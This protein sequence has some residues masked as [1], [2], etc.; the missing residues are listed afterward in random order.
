MNVPV[1]RSPAGVVLPA[2]VVALLRDSFSFVGPGS[3]LPTTGPTG[4]SQVSTEVPVYEEPNRVIVPA[5]PVAIL[6][7]DGTFVGPGNPLPTTGGGGGPTTAEDVSLAGHSPLDNVQEALDQLLYV[8]IDASPTGGGSANE[9]GAS[10]ASVNFTWSV[11]KDPTTQSLN[12][13]VGSIDPTLRDYLFTGPYTTNQTF[14]V[15]VS[16]GTTSDQASVS[17]TFQP[18]RYWGTSALTSLNNAQ[19]LALSQELS[20]SRA[21]SLTYDC[22]GG[23]YPYFIY[24]TSLGALTS[25]TVGGLAFSDFTQSIQSVTNAQGYVQN[26]YV[27]RFNGIQTGAAINVSWA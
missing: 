12:Q 8:A 18:K 14:T 3:P 26:Y 25:V 1:Y 22:T 15:T 27:T 23:A 7:S 9:I 2:D 20:S 4:A 16:D 10:V 11:N 19:I 17:V 21:K 5:Q 13:G 24:P 6:L